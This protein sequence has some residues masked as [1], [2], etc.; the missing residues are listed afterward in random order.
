MCG[1]IEAG[2]EGKE[3]QRRKDQH[4]A[5]GNGIK[6]LRIEVRTRRGES[7]C[8]RVARRQ[9]THDDHERRQAE[10]HKAQ[11]AMN[12]HAACRDERDLRDQQKNPARKHRAVNVDDH[13]GKRR[14]EHAGEK[15][16]ACKTHKNGGQNQERHS[17]EKE[18]IEMA[19]L[20]KPL[21]VASC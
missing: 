14:P 9:D 2:A 7:A 4:V 18:I 21:G 6:R 17:R 8:E 15:I 19:A 5:D 10:T 1:G 11:A 3:N 13:A 12:I 20:S 16:S